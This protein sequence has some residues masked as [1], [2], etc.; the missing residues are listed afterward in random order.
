MKVANIAEVMIGKQLS[1]QTCKFNSMFDNLK[2][3]KPDALGR[4]ESRLVFR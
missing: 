2:E 4:L 3:L 1:K